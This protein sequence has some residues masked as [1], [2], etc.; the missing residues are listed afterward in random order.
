MEYAKDVKLSNAGS[1]D[2]STGKATGDNAAAAA[3]A[4]LG[5]KAPSPQ[6]ALEVGTVKVDCSEY[7]K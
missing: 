1:L 2:D 7:K 4:N 5:G 3:V 6:A